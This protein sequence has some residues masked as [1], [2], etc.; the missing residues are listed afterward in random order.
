MLLLTLHEKLPALLLLKFTSAVVVLL[1]PRFCRIP[2]VFLQAA[3]L[4]LRQI[5][6]KHVVN[7]ALIKIIFVANASH[8]IIVKYLNVL[9]NICAIALNQSNLFLVE[10]QCDYAFFVF[11]G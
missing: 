1:L 10:M 5:L 6:A 2:L 9:A 8:R 11:L 4:L 3:I 7:S